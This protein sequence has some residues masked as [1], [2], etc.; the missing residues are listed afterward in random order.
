M[1]FF[2]EYVVAD[3]GRNHLH[4]ADFY[5]RMDIVL[6]DVFE[7]YELLPK[8]KKKTRHF[9]TK[10]R[11]NINHTDYFSFKSYLPLYL[12]WCY[13]LSFHKT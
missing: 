2:M 5:F 12:V 7:N 4:I 3:D 8:K 1:V 11:S 9:L 6:T 10:K 13:V